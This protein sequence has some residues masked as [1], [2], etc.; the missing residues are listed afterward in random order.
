MVWNTTKLQA[1]L[2]RWNSYRASAVPAALSGRV[3]PEIAGLVEAV[4]RTS[5]GKTWLLDRTQVMCEL[6]MTDLDFDELP[7]EIEAH[8]PAHGTRRKQTTA[9]CMS[10]SAPD[11]TPIFIRLTPAL[12]ILLSANLVLWRF[13]FSGRLGNSLGFIKLSPPLEKPNPCH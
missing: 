1:A 6:G 13:E 3:A 10:M 7:R 8:I 4:G 5:V 2:D 11:R 9:P 12:R